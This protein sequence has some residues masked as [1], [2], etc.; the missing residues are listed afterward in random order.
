MNSHMPTLLVKDSNNEVVQL[1]PYG[2][3]QTVAFN[4]SAGAAVLSG[5]IIR[6]VVRLNPTVDCFVMSTVAGSVTSA[7]G[8]F[9]KAYSNTDFPLIGS[10][11]KISILAVGTGAGTMY[12]SEL[13]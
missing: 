8:H 1:M 7:T 6:K 11:T 4:G 10:D 3:P 2:A 13:G 9:I 5:A 12:M